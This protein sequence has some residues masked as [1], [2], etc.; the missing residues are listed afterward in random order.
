[1]TDRGSIGF[2][3]ETGEGSHGGQAGR[4]AALADDAEIIAW[5]LAVMGR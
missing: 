4:Y 5:A 1:M 3:V 2:R